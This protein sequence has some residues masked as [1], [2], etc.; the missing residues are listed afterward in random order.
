MQHVLQDGEQVVDLGGDVPVPPLE[1]REAG[2]EIFLH[3]EQ[4]KDLPPWGTKAT[5]ARARS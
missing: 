5:P 4:G 3:R 1:R 2:L